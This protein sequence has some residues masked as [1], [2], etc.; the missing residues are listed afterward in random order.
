MADDGF[1]QFGHVPRAG[2]VGIDP[3]P[4]GPHVDARVGA[5]VELD[6]RP[7][8]HPADPDEGRALGLEVARVRDAD[9]AFHVS[10]GFCALGRQEPGDQRGPVGEHGHVLVV[11]LVDDPGPD[12]VAGDLASTVAGQLQEAEHAVEPFDQ[13]AD[14]GVL[15]PVGELGRPCGR[16]LPGV[17]VDPGVSHERGHTVRPHLP[18]GPDPEV[19]RSVLPAGEVEPFGVVGPVDVIGGREGELSWCG[20]AED[21]SHV[22][23]HTSSGSGVDDGERVHSKLQWRVGGGR[24]GGW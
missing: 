12:R 22:L 1:D 8:R 6:H 3:G 24:I 15:E 18:A 13:R 17:G 9:R 4:A 19:L 20:R 16:G 21:P 11:A 23:G 14:A 5:R 2:Q 7:E 10:H